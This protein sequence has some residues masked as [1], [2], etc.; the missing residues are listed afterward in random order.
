MTTHDEQLAAI[1][2]A[3]LMELPITLEDDEPDDRAPDVWDSLLFGAEAA[4]LLLALVAGAFALL[5]YFFG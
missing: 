3:H 5:G 4:L 1:R 2:E